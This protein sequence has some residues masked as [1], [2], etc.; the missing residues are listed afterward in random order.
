MAGL[1]SS[2]PGAITHAGGVVRRVIDGRREYLLVQ[3]RSPSHEWV[4]PKGHIEPGEA[5]E[6]AAIREVREEAGVDAKIVAPLGELR[7]D[8]GTAAMFLMTCNA[9][10]N[11]RERA[12]TWLT[13]EAAHDALAFAESRDLLMLADQIAG[14]RS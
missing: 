8:I 1:S 4:F 11:I 10:D 5:A 14:G 9:A 12:I 13:F 6:R 7:L 3:T 2:D